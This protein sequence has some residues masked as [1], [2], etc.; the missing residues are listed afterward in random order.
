MGRCGLR[1]SEVNY[2]GPAELW[3]SEGGECWRFEVRGK[4]TKSGQ[5]TMRD[6]WM[7]EDVQDDVHKYARERGLGRGIRG[8]T[9]GVR[10]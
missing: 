4:N 8:E 6:A 10:R 3:W 5:K 7:P 9:V 2:P 1:A